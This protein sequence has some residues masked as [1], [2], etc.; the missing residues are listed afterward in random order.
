[1]VLI[2]YVS[3]SSKSNHNCTLRSS[4]EVTK[5]GLASMRVLLVLLEL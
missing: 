5:C 4:F 3:L 2:G 1:M